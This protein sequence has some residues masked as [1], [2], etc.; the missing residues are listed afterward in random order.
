MNGAWACGVCTAC[1][2][3]AWGNYVGMGVYE[4]EEG[5]GGTRLWAWAP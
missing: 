4:G 3:Y 2:G 5:E 1:V